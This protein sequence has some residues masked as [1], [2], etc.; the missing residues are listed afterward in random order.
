MES[1]R[2]SESIDQI[3]TALAAAQ[4]MIEPAD[5]DAK[6]HQ[7]KYATL[8]SVRE[9]SRIPLSKNGLALIQS[10]VFH[11]G[12]IAVITRIIHTSGQWIES[13]ISLRLA[14]DDAHSMGSAITYLRRYSQSSM[15]GIVADD[16]D[17]GAAA[18]AAWNKNKPIQAQNSQPQIS[19]VPKENITNYF[20]RKNEEQNKKIVSFLT[21][22]GKNHLLDKIWGELEGKP[23]NPQNFQDAYNLVLSNDKPQLGNDHN[24]SIP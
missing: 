1:L 19:Q 2:T 21:L 9:A 22:N 8:L 15:L 10:P 12:R 5:K 18:V 4:G 13:E 16:D 3:A 24:E 14:K 7:A 6:S 11:D 20:S 17:D 23:Q